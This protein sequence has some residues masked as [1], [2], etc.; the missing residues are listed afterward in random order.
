MR[1]ILFNSPNTVTAV[2]VSSKALLTKTSQN[3]Q[4]LWVEAAYKTQA[5]ELLLVLVYVL[6][7][8]TNM[9][10]REIMMRLA[11]IPSNNKI[12]WHHFMTS[13]YWRYFQN[14]SWFLCT[15]SISA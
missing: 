2:K 13:L 7:T 6:T 10:I 4:G 14:S 11:E 1:S 9:L 15:Y 12:L 5:Y 8:N 3:S